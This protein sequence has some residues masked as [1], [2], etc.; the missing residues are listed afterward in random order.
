MKWMN[1]WYYRRSTTH[2]WAAIGL[3]LLLVAGVVALFAL[4]S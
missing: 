2:L 1:D 3:N 4:I